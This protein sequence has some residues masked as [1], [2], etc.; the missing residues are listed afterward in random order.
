MMGRRE[1]GEPASVAAIVVVAMITSPIPSACRWKRRR[2]ASNFT[3][4]SSST[5]SSTSRTPTSPCVAG[6][7]SIACRAHRV[8][9]TLKRTID[10]PPTS[11]HPI[12]TTA[13]RS[14]AT[15]GR[16][17]WSGARVSG[18]IVTRAARPGHS[19]GGPSRG[20][21][22]LRSS[23][24]F[25]LRRRR[26]VQPVAFHSRGSRGPASARASARPATPRIAA[27]PR[28]VGLAVLLH[29]G[30][31]VAL[32]VRAEPRHGRPAGL[33]ERDHDDDDQ[34]DRQGWTP[35]IQSL[36]GRS[37]ATLAPAARFVM[38]RR[39]WQG[40][41][42]R[43]GAAYVAALRDGRAVYLDGERVKDVT[44]HPAFA[45]PIRRIAATYERAR[46]AEADPALTYADP[47]RA[48]RH[49]NM[50]LV[51]RSAEDLGARRR[52]HRFWAEPSYG[53]MGRTPDHV[54]CV[55][56]AF[57]AWRQLFDRGGAPFGDNVVRFY[58]RARDE[59]LY[60]AYAIVP[61]QVDRSQPA[62][63]HPEPFLH[64]GVLR[65]RD[66]GIV[67]RGA[68]AIAT[69]ATLADWLFLSYITPLVP[70]DEDYAISLVMPMNAEGLRLYPRRPYATAATSVFD[71][72]LSSRFDEI[73][74][75]VV[76]NDVFVP[77]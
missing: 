24:R 9:S 61:P 72:P 73:D 13:V 67:V 8:S 14:T 17:H 59:D 52:V 19:V 32:D 54:A 25:P 53:L 70:G 76:F 37:C 20:T 50:W 45:E 18:I 69:S 15:G 38:T 26:A 21:T 56:T 43:T 44:S 57:A 71:Y 49:S 28:A 55:L 6:R 42:V 1:A 58:E 27:L 34:D 35:Q 29:A 10:A 5:R 2:P 46:A 66:G 47:A 51:P 12:S 62:H 30:G 75:T 22:R 64:P 74:T 40:G 41:R 16:R 60:L 39:L 63:R 77:W 4:A 48:T 3:S 65:E 23:F 68:Q 36:P 7:A 33:A 11:A 31:G